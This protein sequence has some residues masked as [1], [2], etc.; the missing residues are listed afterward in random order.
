MGT[1][2]LTSGNFRG[3]T[4]RTIKKILSH[5]KYNPKSV[6]YDVGIAVSAQPIIFTDF[7]RS[8]CLP[9]L[10][11]DNDDHYRD[12]FMTLVGWSYDNETTSENSPRKYDLTIRS[13]KVGFIAFYPISLEHAF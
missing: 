3:G 13:L 8:V 2:N 4:E 6:Y 1:S 9:Y 5:P 10:P 7:V 12:K 11:I